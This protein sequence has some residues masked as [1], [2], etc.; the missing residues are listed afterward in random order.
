[1]FYSIVQFTKRFEGY[2]QS[3]TGCTELLLFIM[4]NRELFADEKVR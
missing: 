1:M 4:D 3:S 2:K